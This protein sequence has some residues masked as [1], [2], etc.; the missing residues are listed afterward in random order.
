MAIEKIIKSNIDINTE[1]DDIDKNYKNII[2]KM[3]NITN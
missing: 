2:E 1:T 3:N